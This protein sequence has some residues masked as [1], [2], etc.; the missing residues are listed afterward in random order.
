MR[1]RAYHGEELGAAGLAMAALRNKREDRRRAPRVLEP[2]KNARFTQG[3][4]YLP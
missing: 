1:A 4:L 2:L 3:H